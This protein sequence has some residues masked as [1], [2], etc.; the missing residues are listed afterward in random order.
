MCGACADFITAEDQ[1]PA[2]E[3]LDMAPVMDRRD[4]VKEDKLAL[5][6]IVFLKGVKT[7]FSLRLYKNELTSSTYR[8]VAT[9][10]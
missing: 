9:T 4:L 8:M 5:A 6:F 10:V 1:L 3:F 2:D 7:P